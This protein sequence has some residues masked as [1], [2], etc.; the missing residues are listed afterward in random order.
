MSSPLQLSTL[1]S[2]SSPFLLSNSQQTQSVSVDARS[3]TSAFSSGSDVELDPTISS[4]LCVPSSLHSSPSASYLSTNSARS[5]ILPPLRSGSQT[6]HRILSFPELPHTSAV[7]FS[8]PHLVQESNLEGT[9][10]TQLVSLAEST[11]PRFVVVQ[12]ASKRGGDLLVEEGFTYVK[13]KSSIIGQRWR[14]TVRNSSVRCKGLVL[15]QGSSFS[16]GAQPHMCS[17]K[18]CA[19]STAQIKLYLR[20][21]GESRPHASGA[22]LVKEALNKF[23]PTSAPASDLPSVTCMVRATSRARQK[24]RPKHPSALNFEWVEEALPSSFKQA[25]ILVGSARHVMFFTAFLLSLLRTAKTWYVDATFKAD[26]E[27]TLHAFVCQDSFIKQVPLVMVIMSRRTKADYLAILYQIKSFLSESPSAVVMN[28][29]PA[30]WSAFREVFEAINF[31]GCVFHWKQAVWRKI[32]ELGLR[33]YYSRQSKSRRF[34]LEIMS[35]P[36]LPA[37]QIVATFQDFCNVIQPTHNQSF[38]TLIEYVESQWINSNVFP[39]S[40]WSV[41][42][43]SVRTNN[44]VEGWH[45]MVSTE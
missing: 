5:P 27:H 1:T 3:S 42:G 9:I 17:P 23:L 13:D 16:R 35:L 41:F 43:Q 4:P 36:F 6:C 33:K 34:L 30:V 7:S 31:R 11:E 12:K 28:F 38:H 8:E 2:T 32:K 22:T 21:E 18:N 10:A 19:L 24:S 14:C 39:P 29:E 45:I 37:E 25:D 44:D 40:S 15:Q 20:S 26:M